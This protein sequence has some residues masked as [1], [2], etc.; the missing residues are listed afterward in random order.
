LGG[1]NSIARAAIGTALNNRLAAKPICSRV[2]PARLSLA[3]GIEGF[4][5][6]FITLTKEVTIKWGKKDLM[7]NKPIKRVCEPLTH[8]SACLI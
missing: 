3:I 5:K 4:R 1:I 7:T 8:M 6:T 2:R